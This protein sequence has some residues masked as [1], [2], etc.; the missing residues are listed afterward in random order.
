MLKTEIARI[1]SDSDPGVVEHIV[2]A[3]MLGNRF[4]DEL[5]DTLF[6]RNVYVL[7]AGPTTALTD[8]R[9]DLSS[10]LRINVRHNDDGASGA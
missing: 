10:A 9:G 6:I 4:T 1:A 2:E 7:R 3:L 8:G 5:A